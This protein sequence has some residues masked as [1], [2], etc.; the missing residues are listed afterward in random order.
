MAQI[1]ILKYFNA[2]NDNS[3]FKIGRPIYLVNGYEHLE[4]RALYAESY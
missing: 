2:I 3:A 4:N 1:L